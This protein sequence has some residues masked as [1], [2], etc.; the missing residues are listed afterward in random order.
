MALLMITYTKVPSSMCVSVVPILGHVGTQ[1]EAYEPLRLRLAIFCR[2]TS[3][4]ITD[5]GKCSA[6]FIGC[7]SAEL[8]Q[9]LR[10]IKEGSGKQV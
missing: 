1:E 2:K 6:C 9:V 3:P 10:G 4:R 7:M 8:D 5:D